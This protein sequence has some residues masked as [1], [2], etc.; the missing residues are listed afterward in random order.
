M[1]FIHTTPDSELA[2]K[3]AEFVSQELEK[4][5]SHGSSLLLLSGGSVSSD[6]VLPLIRL[7]DN[8]SSLQNLHIALVDERYGEP[9][10]EQSNQLLLK[11]TGLF[12]FLEKKKTSAVF[13][14]GMAGESMTQIGQMYDK[15]LTE[16]FEISQGRI[17][18]ILGIGEDGHTAGIKP[19]ENPEA[20]RQLFD[21]DTLVVE[22]THSDFQRITLSPKG[23]E[24]LTTIVVYAK[25]E[26]KRPALVKLLS[27]KAEEVY[28]Y[29]ALM[30]KKHL[31]CHV[32]TDQEVA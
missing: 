31:N 1:V 10:H 26:K 2:Q 18:G 20:Y 29:P 28:K 8:L 4:Y 14:L 25:G 19:Q 12:D 5:L 21:Q 11:N 22:Y 27:A 7:L 17:I 15:K 16:L 13:P 30:L 3:T 6:V 23:I 9:F 32:F 24:L